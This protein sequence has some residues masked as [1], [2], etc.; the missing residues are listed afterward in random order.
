MKILREIIW[1]N[2][3]K[4]KRSS[5]AIM[6]ALFLMTTLM[7]CFSGMVYTMWT[8]AVALEKW[9]NGNW[10]GELFDETYG[11]DL[12]KLK[13]FA[14]VDAVLLK[15]PWEVAKLSEEGR[16][17]YVISRGA[18]REY[19]ESM[20]EKDGILRGRVPE[21]EQE[22]VLSKQYFDEH[23]D[24]KIGDTLTLPVGTRMQNGQVCNPTEGVD[25]TEDF[26][27]TG[28]KT[29]TI[30]GELD[31]VTSSSVPGYTGMTY[32][33]EDTIQP[34]DVLTVYLRFDPMRRT[35]QELPALAESIG[36][37]QDEYGEY[38]LRYNHSLLSVYG[39]FPPKA[40]AGPDLLV[41]LSV[42]L[43]FLAFALLLVGVFVLV[44]HN[45]FAVS[46]NDKLEQVG[47]LSGIGASGK[48]IQKM[49]ITEALLLSVPP[50][51]PGLAAG[52][53]LDKKLF[54]LINA[55][56][57]VGRQGP[58]IVLT[59]GLPAILPSVLLS[60]LTVWLSARIP[61]KK[62]AKL[63][64]V[65]I[66]KQ[67]GEGQIFR[68][69]KRNRKLIGGILGELAGNA[70]YFRKKAY[71]A[72]TMSL[73]LSFLLLTGFQY[74]IT[75][76][77]ATREIYA[78]YAPK[79]N[80]I[81]VS[82]SDGR[83]PDKAAIEAM[84]EIPGLKPPV[85]ETTLPCAIWVPEEKA[86]KDLQTHLGGFQGIVEMG[87]YSPIERDGKY[88]IQV[89]LLGL[90][91]DS[92][93]AYCEDLGVDSKQYYQ[94]ASRALV[95]NKTKDP[96][97]STK[98]ATVMWEL[99]DLKQ[100]ELLTL[101]EKN[102]D[103]IEG[104]FQFSIQAYEFTD[105]LPEELS[106]P[107]FYS[108]FT[109]LA[110]MPMEHVQALG[111]SCCEKRQGTA[112]RFR[113]YYD[114]EETGEISNTDIDAAKK[115]VEDVINQYYGSGDFN[116][117]SLSDQE[118]MDADTRHAMNLIFAFLTCFLAV[119]GL[120]NIWA[121]ISANLRQR[122]REF[123]MLKSVGLTPGQLWKMLCLEGVTL[124]LKPLLYTIPFQ[125]VWIG[126]FLYTSQ[127]T[128]LEYLPFFPIRVLGVYILLVLLAILGAYLLGGL[129]LQRE[130]VIE[131]VKDDTI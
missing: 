78:A 30:V 79:E 72:A 25:E 106:N 113:A 75:I 128:V 101:T 73:C 28:T 23:P 127:I 55:T 131:A 129:K 6:I 60:L 44:I 43:M 120:S 33:E 13:N 27:Q 47:I 105:H 87:K 50:M 112:K 88:R 119:I 32:L 80:H 56:N 7:S 107:S 1:D 70:V 121:T 12:E 94:D 10:H 40:D 58:E 86:S 103:A 19:W 100:G 18:N 17:I 64:P 38:T 20:P 66:Q 52:W 117:G 114:L 83:W 24:T 84:K 108:S 95:Y 29:Y 34:E 9:H 115:K 116:I 111:A 99:L 46:V 53:F 54:D 49:V 110:V 51:I 125:A 69:K 96:K 76:Q 48:Q 35:Y 97:A 81:S 62:A 67:Q 22:L 36:Y 41:S 37:E 8:D 26:L 42:P 74:L 21:T 68:R 59:F 90:E 126:A 63:L 130:S 109:L 122:R 77:D 14:S 3:R 45:A 16:R 61:A 118:K 71:R 89:E 15:G 4:N 57:D 65:E 93:H 5:L 123:A 124:G 11:R 82:V 85:I 102:D 31:A 92:F 2:M 91:K 104:D 98:R 39:I